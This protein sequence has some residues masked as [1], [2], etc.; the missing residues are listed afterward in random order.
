MRLHLNARKD[1]ARCR[2]VMSPPGR[3][4]IKGRG[5]KMGLN[6]VCLR[7]QKK[8]RGTTSPWTNE[9]AWCPVCIMGS[10]YNSCYSHNGYV[11]GKAMKMHPWE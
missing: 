2:V 6:M 1:P 7:S 3:Q 8:A 5:P 11:N 10:A 9:N 4:N